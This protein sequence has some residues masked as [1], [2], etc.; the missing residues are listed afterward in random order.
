MKAI[1]ERLALL[2]GDFKKEEIN[3]TVAYKCNTIAEEIIKEHDLLFCDGFYFEYQDG[4]YRPITE[5]TIKTYIKEK[6]GKEFSIT[7]MSLTLESITLEI[8]L[9]NSSEL[10]SSPLINVKNGML[11]LNTFELKPHSPEYRSTIQLDV[12]FNPEAMAPKWFATL[13]D[14][15]SDDIT[16]ADTLQEFFG[17]CLTKETKFEK[18]LFLVGEGANGKS[19]VLHILQKILGK[20]NYSCI[21][22]ESFGNPNYVAGLYQKLANFSTETNAKSSVYDSIFKA[23]ISGDQITAD[24][25]YQNA[26]SFAPVSKLVFA[27]NSLPRV[28]DK[29]NAF[30]R[31][32]LI[33]R[34]NREFAE[35]EQ[36]K[37]LKKELEAELDGIF[38]WMLNGLKALNQRGY[39]EINDSIK[40]EI[41]E[42][43]LENNNT[44]I[45]IE[46]AC[47]QLPSQSIT[48]NALYEAYVSFSL[49]NGHKASSK[50]R[51][52]MELKKVKGISE[53]I[54]PSG[55]ERIWE[56]IGLK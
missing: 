15:F 51:F 4:A 24:L 6:F 43:R 50:K 17:L 54:S 5:R 19:T 26:F 28:D 21:P 9:D 23:I 31:R 3:E 47:L 52:G 13:R 42:Y 32:L 20:Q 35:A 29:S 16:K 30:Y 56:G 36:N 10:N 27:L 55:N 38:I 53:G 12:N 37:T 44:L 18:A 45:F 11:D 46:E 8:C 25:K 22:L 41:E 7:K 34:F 39:F 2:N 1:E 33:I 49:K 48:K 14:I 40:K